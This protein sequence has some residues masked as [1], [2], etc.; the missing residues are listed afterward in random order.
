MGA[1]GKIKK[2][3]NIPRPPIVAMLGHVDHGKTSLLDAIRNARVQLCEAGGITQNIRA[4]KVFYKAA[5]N[6]KYSVTFIDT[7]GHEAF[8]NMRL[9]GANVTD[10]GVLVVAADDGVQPQTIEA[11]EFLKDANVPIVVAINKIDVKGVDILKVK[12]QLS[13]VGIQVEELGGDVICVETSAREKKGLDDLLESIL[14]TFELSFEGEESLERGIARVIVLESKKDKSFGPISLCIVKSGKFKAGNYFVCGNMIGKIRTIKTDNFCDCN[15]ARVSDPIWIAGF[16]LEMPVGADIY[17]YESQDDI[18]AYQKSERIEIKKSKE[19]S[20]TEGNSI[21]EEILLEFLDNQKKLNE[22]VL[23]VIVK[24]ESQGT[25]EVVLEELKKVGNDNVK[26]NIPVSGTGEITEDDILKA[27]VING[28]VIGFKSKVAKKTEKIAKIE[29]VLVKNYEVIYELL[30][31]VKE[32]IESIKDKKEV[33]VEISRA[34]IKK[35]FKLSDGSLVAGCKVVKG[36]ILKGYQCYIERPSQEKNNILGWAK[37]VSL[38][39]N[40]DEIK[41]ASKDTECG[42]LVDPSVEFEKD[43]EIVCYKI[44]KE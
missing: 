27:K 33:K 25:L 5:D 1:K 15:E 30:D 28:I 10:V 35:V 17:I 43:D 34:K 7:P 41:E 14:L 20:Q 13:D 4:H 12:R 32:V 36:T 21:D 38:K 37:I 18:N 31:E 39:H 22:K 2:K 19:K 3:Y 44:E 26:I 9:R 40:K 6:F 42:I 29:K 16:R 8:S 23:N 24:S 11:I